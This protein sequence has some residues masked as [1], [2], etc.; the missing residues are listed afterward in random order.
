MWIIVFWVVC[1]SSLVSGGTYHFH[2][3]FLKL[4][5]TSSSETLVTT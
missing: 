4:E 1:P 5:A 3:S 2:R